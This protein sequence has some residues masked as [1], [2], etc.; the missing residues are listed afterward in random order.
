[1]ELF[2]FRS[3]GAGALFKFDRFCAAL[4]CSGRQGVAFHLD[5]WSIL[6]SRRLPLIGDVVPIE[7]KGRAR[8]GGKDVAVADMAIARRF[9]GITGLDRTHQLSASMRQP[10][11]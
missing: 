1:M 3:R 7:G 2:G 6:A 8:T 10:H 9:L 4:F 11:A 5:A